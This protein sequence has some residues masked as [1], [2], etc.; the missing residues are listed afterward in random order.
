MRI[1]GRAV[2]ILTRGG[3]DTQRIGAGLRHKNPAPVTAPDIADGEG[4]DK[5][6]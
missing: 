5:D 1:D 4:H 2:A 3:A 6:T